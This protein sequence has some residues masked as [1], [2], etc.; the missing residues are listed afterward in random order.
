MAIQDA[1]QDKNWK[2]ALLAHTGTAGTAETIRVTSQNTAGA[3]DVHIAGGSAVVT[4]GTFTD[5]TALTPSAPAVGTVGVSSAT[6]VGSNTARKGLILV[7][8]SPN[9]VSLAVN[10]TAVLN[11]GMTIYPGGVFNMDSYNFFLGTVTAIAEA[12]SGTVGIQ[13]YT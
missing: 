4:A 7:N 1:I 12:A 2:P 5:R 6:L 13:E 3:V 8:T 9:T 11:S 10:A